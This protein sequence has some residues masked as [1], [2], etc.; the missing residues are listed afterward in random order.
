VYALGQPLPDQNPLGSLAVVLIGGRLWGRA[1]S[2]VRLWI[3]VRRRSRVVFRLSE[4]VQA[5]AF[6][7]IMTWLWVASTRRPALQP[8]AVQ[9]S[10]SDIGLACR[11]RDGRS[12]L[13]RWPQTTK[14]PF[15]PS[16]GVRCPWVSLTYRFHT[17]IPKA[18]S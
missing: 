16:G 18:S 14:P 11:E 3:L 8:A 2:S 7:A 6:V 17:R 5:A 10:S 13:Y 12:G 15:H 1:S 4:R 9:T